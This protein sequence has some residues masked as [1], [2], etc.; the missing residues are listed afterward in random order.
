MGDT[1]IIDISIQ[2]NDHIFQKPERIIVTGTS[3]SGKTFL[4]ENL[5][6]KF[7]HKF[8]RIIICGNK[9]KLL[10][11]NETREKTSLFSSDTDII[12]NPFLEIGQYEVKKYPNQQFLIIIDDLMDS[13]FKST[14]VSDIFSKGRHINVSCIILN[15]S[16]CPNGTGTNL[17]PQ[18]KNNATIHVFTKCRAANEVRL[19]ASRLEFDKKSQD[20]FTNLYKKYVLEKKY[21]YIFV[22]M[23]SGD[24]KLKYCNNF[25]SE[26]GSPFLTVFF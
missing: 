10:E 22:M 4:I 6:R 18:I 5:V 16:F 14:I 8:Y 17:Y 9:N 7:S 3:N 15:Q 24:S 20:T 12:Y 26:D 23:D 19:I 25:L 11:F 13:V 1:G 2:D 21:G